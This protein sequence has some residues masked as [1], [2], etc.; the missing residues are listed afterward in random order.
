MQL[1]KGKKQKYSW[2]HVPGVVHLINKEKSHKQ[3]YYWYVQ[4]YL[5]T[6]VYPIKGP[7]EWCMLVKWSSLCENTKQHSHHRETWSECHWVCLHAWRLPRIP[8]V[9]TC[10][11]PMICLLAYAAISNVKPS[12]Q[13]A[14]G[15]TSAAVSPRMHDFTYWDSTSGC[16]HEVNGHDIK[17]GTKRHSTHEKKWWSV[18]V[19]FPCFLKIQEQIIFVMEFHF[20][21]RKKALCISSCK[22]NLIIWKVQGQDTWHTAE[23]L[24]AVCLK[25]VKI[26]ASP[27]FGN[28]L[29]YLQVHPGKTGKQCT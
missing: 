28:R 6:I 16:L 25:C 20:C 1:H 5:H 27:W 4:A 22:N 15:P 29:Q 24:H 7:D 19:P 9:I 2:Q 10:P 14:P 17:C 8:V 23:Y 3:L 21:Q 13:K 18:D 26:N 11:V 12:K